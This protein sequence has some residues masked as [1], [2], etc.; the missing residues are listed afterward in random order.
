MGLEKES[1]RVSSEGGIARTPHPPALGSALTNAFITTDYSEALTE[2]IT[3]PLHGVEAALDFL[4]DI[5][6][7][8]YE[9]LGDEV[10]WA[11]SMP[12]VLEG[13]ANIPI[14]RYGRSNT[15]CMKTIY[16]RGLGHRYGRMMQV[17]AGVH[18]NYSLPEGF[19]P[20]FQELER[21][22]NPARHFIDERY[23]GLIRNLQ[24]Y[25]WLIPYLLGASPAICK[26]F[27]G[28]KPTTLETF[29]RSTCYAPFATS[30]RMGDIGYTNKKEQGVGI[31]ACYDSLDAYVA[32]LT[33]AIETSC[34]S[35]EPIGIEVEGQYKQLN[36]NILQIENEYYSTVRPK[37]P[38]EGLEK[39]TLALRCRGVR[40]VELRSLDVN[41]FEPLGIGMAQLRF[42][43]AFMIFCLLQESPLID[44]REQREIDWNLEDVAHRGRTPSLKLLWQGRETRLRDWAQE[45]LDAMVGICEQL[46][47]G[48]TGPHAAA[49]VEQRE[50]VLDPDRTPSARMLAEMREHGEGFFAFAQRLSHR[51]R[52]YFEKAELDPGRRA[53]LQREVQFSRE[54]QFAMEQADDIPFRE[55]LDNYFAQR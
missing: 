27:L 50:L 26:S 1:L 2:F 38:P 3:P 7:F 25:G 4:C 52:C 22:R 12:C 47:G 33:N 45:I 48:A 18:Y 11:T 23:F 29:D 30:L 32:S 42:L 41:A 19:W 39:P 10:L 20:L 13:G 31:K 54:R 51:H 40:Y 14:A 5:Q 28:G 35:W 46:D 43:E 49:L 6:K 24:R 53:L 17:I 16:R 9:N 8:V 36:S 44:N 21:D 37:Q 15:G 55:F 34:S